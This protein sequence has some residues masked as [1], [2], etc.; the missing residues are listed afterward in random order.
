MN[1]PNQK[2]LRN[3]IS[4]PM[5]GLV[6]IFLGLAAVIG[7]CVNGKANEVRSELLQLRPRLKPEAQAV[8]QRGGQAPKAFSTARNV[9]EAQTLRNEIYS[10][11]MEVASRKYHTL[12]LVFIGCYGMLLILSGAWAWKRVGILIAR[13]RARRLP[14]G[15]PGRM[16]TAIFRVFQAAACVAIAAGVAAI[17]A[18]I[19]EDIHCLRMLEG[20]ISAPA[21]SVARQARCW[22]IWATGISAFSSFFFGIAACLMTPTVLARS[23]VIWEMIVRANRFAMRARFSILAGALFTV[24]LLTGPG[25]DIVRTIATGAYS[26]EVS[27]SASSEP[28]FGRMGWFGVTVLIL[29]VTCW[30]WA[31]LVLAV[32][33]ARREQNGNG[34]KRKRLGIEGRLRRDLPIYYGSVPLVA[35]AS[36]FAIAPLRGESSSTFPTAQFFAGSVAPLLLFLFLPLVLVF[37]RADTK[38]ARK[39]PGP[40][41]WT[42]I[43]YG[44]LAMVHAWV[45]WPDL[46]LLGLAPMVLIATALFFFGLGYAAGIFILPAA[47]LL[48]VAEHAILMLFERVAPTIVF[49]T[50]LEAVAPAAVLIAIGY[51]AIRLEKRGPDVDELHIPK[52]FAPSMLLRLIFFEK[53]R[54]EMIRQI[55]N[56]EAAIREMEDV[57]DASGCKPTDKKAALKLEAAKIVKNLSSLLW[58]CALLT[59]LQLAVFFIILRSPEEFPAKMGSG[60]IVALGIAG[61]A[62]AG[63]ALLFITQ[64]TRFPI[65]GAAIVVAVLCSGVMDNHKLHIAGKPS[66]KFIEAREHNSS[67]Q[68]PKDEPGPIGAAF[69]R[70]HA[71]AESEGAE[72]PCIIVAAEGGGIRA[73]FW[74]AIV[75]GTLQDESSERRKSR[76]D[77]ASHIFAISGVSGGSFGAAVFTA[78]CADEKNRSSGKIR[79]VAATICGKDH[80]APT[81]G[82]LLYPDF[83]QRFLPFAILPDRAAAFEGSWERAWPKDAGA[84]RMEQRFSTLW[85]D[86]KS[87]EKNAD[88]WLP[89]LFLNSTMVETGKRV[90]CSN[91]PVRTDDGGQFI[92]AHDLHAHLR[93]GG[94]GA[95]NWQDIRLSTAAHTS[96]RFPVVSPPGR[97]PSGARVVDGGYFENSGAATGIDVLDAVTK[98]LDQTKGATKIIFIFLRYADAPGLTDTIKTPENPPGPPIPDE[99]L[100]LYPQK[101]LLNES[102]S[103]FG[104]LLATRSARGSYSQEAVYNYYLARANVEVL[105]FTFRGEKI[106]LS[107][108]LSQ[109]SCNEMLK[110]FPKTMPESHHGIDDKTWSVIESNLNVKERLLHLLYDD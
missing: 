58:F 84:N 54:N 76:T 101:N 41:S 38:T 44:V 82:A 20:T 16:Q 6:L 40:L 93:T 75:L 81:L 14:A 34:P 110:Q 39:T 50:L 83:V 60:A 21:I 92:D 15:K 70:W 5:G 35:A 59:L 107:W 65:L 22:K 47:L 3:L 61:W 24:L 62:T 2:T 43:V 91:L 10:A 19:V 4:V 26:G 7:A 96:A 71:I 97:L 42:L 89:A 27:A 36:A 23:L 105:S 53:T 85:T 45:N 103:I 109:R 78:L 64:A 74:P 63:G 67:V 80:L 18:N 99:D 77:F 49:L 98:R 28:D 73:A 17:V 66:A 29:A 57:W 104:A 55:E 37:F 13:N 87:E 69:N 51:L 48:G 33:F 94:P 25:E 30:G 102:G 11:K 79:D 68:L 95:G 52:S 72:P 8:L 9:S 1:K 12:D 32:H 88:A 90:I 86:P 31:R 56:D 100:A 46:R 106:P 108:S